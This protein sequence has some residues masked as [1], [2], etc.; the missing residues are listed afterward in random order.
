VTDATHV[1][2]KE[3]CSSRVLPRHIADKRRTNELRVEAGVKDN[4]K[5]TL[6]SSSLTWAGYAERK[7]NEKLAKRAHAQKAEGKRGERE[8]K[9]RWVIA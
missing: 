6:A 5:K 4:F 1:N 9:L 3:M 8:R 7:G 2:L